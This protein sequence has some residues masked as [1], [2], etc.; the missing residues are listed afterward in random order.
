MS[1]GPHRSL[2]MRRAWRTVAERGDKRAFTPTEISEALVPALEQDCQ[3]DMTQA[4]VNGLRRVLEEP[5][6]FPSNVAAR[7][8]PLRS[9][10][11]S[12]IGRELLDNVAL[13]SAAD[14][15]AFQVVQDS[16]KAAL[17]ERAN[18]GARQVEEHYFRESSTPRALNMRGRLDEAIQC[19]DFGAIAERFLGVNPRGKS[20]APV[21]KTGLD[22][23][24]SLP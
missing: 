3:V 16:L 7:L 17:E 18:R 14:A 12:G 23:G 8:E 19:T 24:V 21:K 2:P 20:A 15:E 1:D 9:E 5:L 13:L 6:L 4:F 11:G 22:D 10:A